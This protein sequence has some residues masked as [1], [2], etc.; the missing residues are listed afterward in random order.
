[1]SKIYVVNVIDMSDPAQ[2][3]IVLNCLYRFKY[4]VMPVLLHSI[5]NSRNQKILRTLHGKI[6]KIS[7][8]LEGR[9]D[10]L[11]ISTKFPKLLLLFLKYQSVGSFKIL[12]EPLNYVWS[13]AIMYSNSKYTHIRRIWLSY[14]IATTS[15]IA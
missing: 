3:R 13:S 12:T 15:C 11:G 14:R 1:M 5:L 2:Y 9:L 6:L 10:Y 4:S 7:G 8:F